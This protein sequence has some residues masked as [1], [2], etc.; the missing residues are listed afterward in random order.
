[1]TV[2]SDFLGVGFAA[3]GVFVFDG[4]VF[5]VSTCWVC[6]VPVDVSRVAVSVSGD[7]VGATVRTSE[8]TL[9]FV[10]APNSA[11][12]VLVLEFA[13]ASKVGSGVGVVTGVGSGVG[14][15]LADA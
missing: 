3:T 7:G 2:R 10:F 14:A 15:T 8:F 6:L 11:V 12:D 9:E 1:M 4:V 5:F 13:T